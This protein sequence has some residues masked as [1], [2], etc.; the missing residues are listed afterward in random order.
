MPENHGTSEGQI[1]Q[2][3]DKPLAVMSPPYGDTMGDW[4]NKESN[5]KGQ[6]YAEGGANIGNLPETLDPEQ[7]TKADWWRKKAAEGQSESYLSAMRLVYQQIALVSGVCVTVTKNPTRAGKLRNLAL[8]TFLLLKQAH[9]ML[10]CNCETNLD[11][12]VI[13]LNDNEWEIYQKMV[14]IGPSMLSVRVSHCG[15][16]QNG[17]MQGTQAEDRLSHEATHGFSKGKDKSKA[18]FT[19]I[20]PGDE[21]EASGGITESSPQAEEDLALRNVRDRSDSGMSF[22]PGPL[23]DG[24]TGARTRARSTKGCRVRTRGNIFQRSRERT[25]QCGEVG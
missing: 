12:E 6:L 21:G 13:Q 14:Q 23:Y 4:K 22:L 17:I 8:D 20:Q 7:M 1:G 5:I 10:Y 3:P 2:L 16:E 25:I 18:S 11:E 19:D 9:N 24:P 15:Q